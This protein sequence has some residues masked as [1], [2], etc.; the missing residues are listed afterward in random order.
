MLVAFLF[1]LPS[2][3]CGSKEN[4]KPKIETENQTKIYVSNGLDIEHDDKTNR[5]VK[6]VMRREARVLIDDY[7]WYPPCGDKPLNRYSTCYCGNRTLSGQ[8]DLR[9]GDY[10]C[11]VPPSADGQDQCT[12]GIRYVR[13]ENGEVRHKTQPCHQ[14]SWNSYRQSEKLY[15]TATMYCHKEDYCFP[16]KQM[17]S[18]VCS[19]EAELCDPDK[20]RCI[21]H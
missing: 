16:L 21:R 11:C 6:T 10:Y 17:C 8:A 7:Y 4:K 9:D 19:E 12:E 20:L 2:N 13:C 15:K 1:L 3:I 5:P 18:G 14:N